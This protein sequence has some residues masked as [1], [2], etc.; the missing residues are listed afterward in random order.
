MSLKKLKTEVRREQI[1]QTALGLIASQGVSELKMA[2][3]SRRVGVAPSAIYYHFKSKDEVVDAVL[4][5]LEKRLLD[6][7]KTVTEKSHDPLVRLREI[8]F[9]HVKLIL[10]HSALPR[11]LFSE[12]I[13]GGKPER[14]A[15]LNAIIMSYLDE[16]ARIIREGQQQNRIRSDIRAT[17]L[18]IMFLGLV[19]PTAILWHLSDGVFD[20]AKQVE[21]AWPVFCESIVVR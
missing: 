5:L 4:D 10:E 7:V 17:T 2:G 12:E 20:A 15:K 6:N 21:R 8:L 11:I 9:L 3:L 1:A 18:S 14:K 19:Q 13:Y 16:V